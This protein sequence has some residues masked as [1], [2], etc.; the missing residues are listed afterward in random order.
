MDI[1]KFFQE[2][3]SDW[4]DRETYSIDYELV[5]D[6]ISAGAENLGRQDNNDGTFTTTLLF[7]GKRLIALSTE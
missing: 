7:R 3:L 5:R 1:E 6:F 2:L 4:G